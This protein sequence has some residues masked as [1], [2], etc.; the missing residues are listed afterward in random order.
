[1]TNSLWKENKPIFKSKIWDA[2]YFQSSLQAM[3]AN[4]ILFIYT[5]LGHSLLKKSK[6]PPRYLLNIE[7]CITFADVISDQ[8]KYS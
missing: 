5:Y 1:M 2:E 3:D 4:S 7:S 8:S 6:L